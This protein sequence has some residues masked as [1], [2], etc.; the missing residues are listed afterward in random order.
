[1]VNYPYM[2][3]IKQNKYLFYGI[4]IIMKEKFSRYKSFKWLLKGKIDQVFT[5]NLTHVK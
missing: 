1:M 2:E 3:Y 4:G 5:K